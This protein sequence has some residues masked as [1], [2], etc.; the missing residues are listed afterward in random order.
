MKSGPQFPNPAK[1][2]VYLLWLG[3]KEPEPVG[4]RGVEPSSKFISSYPWLKTKYF[5]ECRFPD[6]YT[7]SARLR[8]VW[9]VKGWGSRCVSVTSICS[10]EAVSITIHYIRECKSSKVDS[11]PIDF[12]KLGSCVP[13]M[14]H[15]FHNKNIV[16]PLW[17]WK[18]SHSINKDD[19]LFMD[20][21]P[22]VL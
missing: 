7:L 5:S 9:L 18:F 14:Y 20:K 3:I 2:L 8:L 21:S 6:S 11:T 17:C 4:R 16:L 13:F 12:G 10:R 22:K 1:F 15:H 19:V